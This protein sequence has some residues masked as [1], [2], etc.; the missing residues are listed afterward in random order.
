MVRVNM[1]RWGAAAFLALASQAAGANG[2]LF[3][4]G[5]IVSNP[6]G[7]TG[8]IAGQPVCQAD[9]F[10]NPLTGGLL[11]SIGVAS[12]VATETACA[13]N[14]RVP[15]GGWNLDTGTFYAFQTGQSV[16]SITM[17]HINLWTAPPFNAQSPAPVPDPLPQPV[18]AAAVQIPVTGGTFVCHRTSHSNTSTNRPVFAYTIPLDAL[19]NQ[20]KLAPG[21]Y[22]LQWSFV[23]ASSP[24][25]NVFM[26]LALR[27]SSFDFNSRLLNTLTGVS[28]DPR[29]WFEGREGF[30]SGVSEGRAYALPFDLAGGSP[31]CVAD[32][33]D[34][35]GSGVFDGG[36]GIEDLLHYL[37]MFEGGGN[38]ADVDDGSGNGVR[39]GGVGIEDLLYYLSRFEAGC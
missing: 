29:S 1:T 33:D 20:G 6:T 19:P 17:I 28:T 8:A 27:S 10:V 39:D 30:V 35:T 26:P 9:S 21:E 14:F 37:L 32:V 11:S 7:G 36:V 34:G 31:D 13:D 3:S 24:T 15:A 23:G 16:P 2:P 18:L 5:Q 38:G 25:A 12:T 4:N 22:W